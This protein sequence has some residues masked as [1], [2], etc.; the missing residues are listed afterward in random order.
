VVSAIG[1]H[2][3][4]KDASIPVTVQIRSV[5]TGLPN[6]VV[7]AEKVVSADEISLSGETKITISCQLNNPQSHNCLSVAAPMPGT[8]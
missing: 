8:C 6:E 3:T 4:Q 7:L 5:T 2:F 1:V